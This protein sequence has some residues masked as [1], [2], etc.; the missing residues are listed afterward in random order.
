VKKEGHCK[1][2]SQGDFKRGTPKRKFNN[3]PQLESEKRKWRKWFP[4]RVKRKKKS[5]KGYF[6]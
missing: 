1:E 4:K 6:G 3:G 5:S 2:D